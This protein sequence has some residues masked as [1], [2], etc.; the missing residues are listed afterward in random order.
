MHACVYVHIYIHM[1]VCLC[2]VVA[3]EVHGTYPDWRKARQHS[4]GTEGA[5]AAQEAEAPH[6]RDI[7]RLHRG[8]AL[9]WVDHANERSE[10]ELELG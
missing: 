3:V 8:P 2:V 4:I 6:P 5:K 1:C 10:L 7:A 9:G